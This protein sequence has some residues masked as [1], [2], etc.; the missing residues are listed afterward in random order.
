MDTVNPIIQ[1]T[2]KQ[3][4]S[5]DYIDPNGI[6]YAMAVELLDT[7]RIEVSYDAEG[8]C[9]LDNFSEGVLLSSHGSGLLSALRTWAIRYN[10]LHAST[11]NE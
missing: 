3:S 8:F 6:D 4:L 10:N 9:H 2:Q 11:P 7:Y 1:A 5:S